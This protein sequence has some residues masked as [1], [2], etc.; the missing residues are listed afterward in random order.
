MQKLG[1]K[2]NCFHDC[3]R[4]QLTVKFFEHGYLERILNTSF[5]GARDACI[6]RNYFKN[7]F[8]SGARLYYGVGGYDKLLGYHQFVDVGQE[9][10]F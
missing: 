9:V 8:V 4:V 3:G 10:V 7:S 6:V 2:R 5:G 1:W